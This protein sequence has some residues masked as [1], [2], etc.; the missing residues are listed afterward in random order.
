M[1]GFL[2]YLA[3]GVLLLLV[4]IAVQGQDLGKHTWLGCLLLILIWPILVLAIG[5]DAFL[6]ALEGN[7]SE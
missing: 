1:T 7:D 5:L 4:T 6:T 2:V 3:L